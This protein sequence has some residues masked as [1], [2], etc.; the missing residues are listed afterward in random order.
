MRLFGRTGTQ[1]SGDPQGGESFLG[2]NLA[3]RI[4][5]SKEVRMQ[6]VIPVQEHP[7]KM[8]AVTKGKVKGVINGVIK[9]E[10]C[11]ARCFL[12]VS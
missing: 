1:P 12:T 8:E 6:A 2:G 10:K 5:P 4:Q 7:T 3:F 9:T 11:W